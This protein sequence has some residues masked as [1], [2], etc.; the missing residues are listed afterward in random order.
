VNT[1][2][3]EDS[4]II[5]TVPNNTNFIEGDLLLTSKDSLQNEFSDSI[6][7]IP[8]FFSPNADLLNGKYELKN[9]KYY[10]NLT[11]SIYNR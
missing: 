6:L 1:T 4:T 10:P 8:N 3:I 11:L 5:V 2:I 9:I 7:V